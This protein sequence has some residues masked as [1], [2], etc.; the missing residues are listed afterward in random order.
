VVFFCSGRKTNVFKIFC[1][2]G[3]VKLD[4]DLREYLSVID[5]EG[6]GKATTSS[7]AGNTTFASFDKQVCFML[8]NYKKLFYCIY[9]KNYCYTLHYAY[10][11]IQIRLAFKNLRSNHWTNLCSCFVPNLALKI[12]EKTMVVMRQHWLL[13]SH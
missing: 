3:A 4:P 12:M 6:V 10:A 11:S 7:N 9:D 2:Q 8:I 1:V 5:D 13:V